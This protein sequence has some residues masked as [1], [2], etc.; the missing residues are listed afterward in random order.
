MPRFQHENNPKMAHLCNFFVC[1]R[2]CFS[3]IALLF[4]ARSYVANIST[5]LT[6][7]YSSCWSVLCASGIAK[8]FW[9]NEESS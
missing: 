5:K 6:L 7:L 3:H 9:T 2:R 8:I 1:R 4:V